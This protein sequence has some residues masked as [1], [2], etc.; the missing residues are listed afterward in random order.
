MDRC[1]AGSTVD[2]LMS[3]ITI[4]YWILN[5]LTAYLIVPVYD[6]PNLLQ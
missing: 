3:F 1:R 2:E 4:H 6:G 5:Y